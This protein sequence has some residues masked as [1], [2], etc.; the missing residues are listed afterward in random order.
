MADY[1]PD[2]FDFFRANKFSQ[3]KQLVACRVH[4]KFLTLLSIETLETLVVHDLWLHP[5][6]GDKTS[7]EDTLKN[8][9]KLLVSFPKLKHVDMDISMFSNPF[10]SIVPRFSPVLTKVEIEQIFAKFNFIRLVYEG[11]NKL[12]KSTGTVYDDELESEIFISNI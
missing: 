10:D 7:Y 8:L 1:F 12:S 9:Y 4:Y 2:H 6:S 11:C 3:L 5:Q